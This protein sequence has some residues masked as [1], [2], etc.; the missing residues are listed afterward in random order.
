MC[1]CL[2]N[3][4]L[5]ILPGMEGLLMKASCSGGACSCSPSPGVIKV[6]LTREEARVVRNAC[7]PKREAEVVLEDYPVL[8]GFIAKL[9]AGLIISMDAL[10]I[11]FDGNKPGKDWVLSYRVGNSDVIH[12]PTQ[13]AETNNQAEYLSLI[14]ALI[15]LR[16]KCLAR[17]LRYFHVIVRGDSQLI[18]RQMSGA[19]RCKNP[20]LQVLHK[21]A[22]GLV[23]S[24][25]N[26][27]GLTF[28]FEWVNRKQNNKALGLPD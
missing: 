10:V 27:F 24:L 23:A 1:H 4:S 17:E 5:P 14:N 12:T 21:T 9:N 11:Y 3:G 26:E 19:Y 2:P 8:C 20:G 13:R 7:E 6:E 22:N 18:L 16:I 15:D 28:D 25:R